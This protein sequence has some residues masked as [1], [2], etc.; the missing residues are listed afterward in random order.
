MQRIL[1]AA[2]LGILFGCAQ[3]TPRAAPT[4]SPL[5]VATG[6]YPH[7][8]HARDFS[9]LAGKVERPLDSGHCLYVAFADKPGAP[10][11]GRLPL[12]GDVALLARL[13]A[14]ESVVVSGALERGLV[15]RCGEPAYRADRVEAN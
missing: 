7:A 2:A 5:P 10:W 13:T 14:G 4:P 15:G 11:G 12:D 9:W 3:E 6:A 8:G 1:A